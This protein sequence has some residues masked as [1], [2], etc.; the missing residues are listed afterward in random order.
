MDKGS[1]PKGRK[2]TKT[3][4]SE[5][6][7]FRRQFNPQYKPDNGEINNLPSKTVPNMSLTI[8]QLLTNHSRG[9]SSDIH[10]NEPQYFDTEIPRFDDITDAIEYK[11]Q[12]ADELKELDKTIK[13][14]QK[15]KSEALK[16]EKLK[17]IPTIPEPP[18]TPLKEVS[19]PKQT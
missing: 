3:G 16:A 12:L 4:T 11:K 7:T 6:L 13:A 19:I 18:Q 1:I 9:I 5:N 2:T 15:A 14:E 17:E 10:H 8:L